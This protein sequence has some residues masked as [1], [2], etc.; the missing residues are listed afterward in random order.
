VPFKLT[1]KL[2]KLTIRIEPPKLT[3]EDKKKLQEAYR[4]AQ[5]AR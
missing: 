3:E 1:A 5:D 4:A 2:D